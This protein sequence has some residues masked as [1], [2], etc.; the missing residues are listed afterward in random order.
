LEINRKWKI[1][2]RKMGLKTTWLMLVVVVGVCVMGG[3]ARGCNVP[4]FRYA[5][6]RWE[7][8]DYQVV[9]F[10]RGGLSGEEKSVVEGL[11]IEAKKAGA[12]VEVRVVDVA[13]D[14]AMSELRERY[15]ELPL[16]WMAVV[17]PAPFDK[18]DAL[19]QVAWAGKVEKGAV[20]NLVDSPKRREIA[21]QLLAG[22]SVVWVMLESGD[23]GK[24]AAAVKVVSGELAKA[25]TP[26]A[27]VDVDQL[28][29]PAIA[30]SAKVP[31]KI[32]FSV[33]RVSRRDA[34]EKWFV[35]MLLGMYPEL[36]E[37]KEALVFPVFGRGRALGAA[38]GEDIQPVV[39]AKGCEFLTGD[40]ACEI[41]EKNPGRD[42]LMAVDWEKQLGERVVVDRPMPALTGVLAEAVATMPAK[43][44][45][46]TV[47]F[48]AAANPLLRNLVIAL[49]AVVAVVV[50]A[51]LVILGRGRK[52]TSA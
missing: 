36:R 50:I 35:R 14:D 22:E 41:K 44:A 9:V 32:G 46:A 27:A 3:I 13:G 26:R 49:G 31:L 1:E 19:P 20:E 38:K 34:A 16:P 52:G 37:T 28:E 30:L 17:Y 48:E 5:L 2:N 4:V 51:T 45:E 43:R 23:A 25:T 7:S 42:L 33:V 18:P 10:C 47:A 21:E 24:D 40:C 39:I 29:P 8:D 11:E 6:E 12:N 15:P